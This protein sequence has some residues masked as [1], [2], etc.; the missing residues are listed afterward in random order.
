MSDTELEEEE[1]KSMRR[2][3]EECHMGTQPNPSEADAHVEE[4]PILFDILNEDARECDDDNPIDDAQ[5][6]DQE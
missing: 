5:D 1:A 6:D 4:E 2:P 3:D